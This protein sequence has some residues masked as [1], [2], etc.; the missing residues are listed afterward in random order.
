MPDW[1]QITRGDA[2]LIVSMS[3][4]GTDMPTEIEARLVSPWRARKDADWHVEKLYDFASA[5][6]NGGKVAIDSAK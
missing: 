3:H 2:P 4:T 5:L 1:L 6:V